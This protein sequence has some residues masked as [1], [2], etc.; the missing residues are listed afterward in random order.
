MMFVLIGLKTPEKSPTAQG[1]DAGFDAGLL[2][3]D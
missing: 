2:V 3:E 1:I